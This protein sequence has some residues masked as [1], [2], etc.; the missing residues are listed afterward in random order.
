MYPEHCPHCGGR[1]DPSRLTPLETS[2]ASM[3]AQ[4]WAASD[5]AE[6][7]GRRT[8][9]VKNM[10]SRIYEKLGV[11]DRDGWPR[12]KLGIYWNCELFQVGLHALGLIAENSS[13]IAA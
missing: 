9:S 4:G 13:E 1:V 6:T 11:H 7:S 5:I 2:V 3:V 10:L 8:Q 12:V